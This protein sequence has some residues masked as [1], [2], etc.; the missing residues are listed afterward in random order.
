[1]ADHCPH[2]G[3]ANPENLPFCNACGEPI[4]PN[5]RIIMDV[6]QSNKTHQEP[7]RTSRYDDDD[8]LEDDD[9]EFE[10]KK[11]PIGIL[12]LV[13]IVAAAAAWFFLK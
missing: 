7:V 9:E 6:Q 5:L 2:C 12:V 8:L 13:I 11:F 3:A 10:E 4:D 1:M